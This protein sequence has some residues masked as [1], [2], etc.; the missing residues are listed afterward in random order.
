MKFI[1]EFKN[2][3][4]LFLN[5][6]REW[7]I[8]LPI[9]ILVSYE[10][11]NAGIL[12]LNSNNWFANYQDNFLFPFNHIPVEI[13]W[14]LVTWTEILGSICLVL[15]FYTRFWAFG[16]LVISIVA[17]SGVH[18]PDNWNDLSELWRGYVIFDKGFGNYKMPFLLIAM[19]V[20]LALSGAGKLSIDAMR[21]S[22][23]KK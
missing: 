20:P 7:L 1:K 18:W 3:T 14:F 9:R 11:G 2:Y 6:L 5:Q 12:K 8:F 10:F 13:S 19:L 22:R 4:F 21:I 16:L 15:G 23:T 17:I